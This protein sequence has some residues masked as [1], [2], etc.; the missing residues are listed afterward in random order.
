M[1]D[2]LAVPVEQAALFL[3]FDGA[4]A[5]LQGAPDE[6]TAT[7]ERTRLLVDFRHNPVCQ[8]GFQ[9]HAYTLRGAD[10]GAFQFVGGHGQ[11]DFRKTPHQI[12]KG[13]IQQRAIIKIGAQGDN[14]PQA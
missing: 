14:H 4:F 10:D 2:S 6:V 11:H 9:H 7:A 13:R 12:T 1:T 3:D 8:T 5:A